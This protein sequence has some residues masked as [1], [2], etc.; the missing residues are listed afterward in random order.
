MHLLA[1]TEHTMEASLYSEHKKGGN[2]YKKKLVIGHDI[3]WQILKV[4]WESV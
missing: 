2:Y 3:Y 1:N 4:R